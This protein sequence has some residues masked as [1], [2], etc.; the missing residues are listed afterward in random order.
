MEDKT[1]ILVTQINLAGLN[2]RIINAYGPQEGAPKDDLL[3][4]WQTLEKEILDAKDENCGVLIE[5]DANAKLGS[6]IIKGDPNEKS[7]NGEILLSLVKRNNLIIANTTS[8][9]NG[10]IT[11]HRIT[12]DK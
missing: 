4:F 6:E 1:E 9:C 11:R 10:T 5:F 3:N 12:K 7:E 8:K 2:I